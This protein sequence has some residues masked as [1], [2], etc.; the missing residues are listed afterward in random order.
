MADDGDLTVKHSRA[1]GT[2]ARTGDLI[3]S[4]IELIDSPRK[5]SNDI[6]DY[7]SNGYAGSS[8]SAS[9]TDCFGDFV[10]LKDF[11]DNGKDNPIPIEEFSEFANKVA[12][13]LMKHDLDWPG[14]IGGRD[15]YDTPFY[16]GGQSSKRTGEIDSENGKYPSSQQVCIEFLGCSGRSEINYMAQ[17]MWGA[18]VDE[19]I[20]IT[21][22][23]VTFW[24]VGEYGKLPSIKTYA[25][26]AYGYFYYKFYSTVTRPQ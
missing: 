15:V 16:N 6:P 26:T 25:W 9:L 17:G 24:K 4:Q 23:I 8:C 19:P 10:S 1:V 21:Y 11:K 3:V 7:P 20:Q 13:D 2:P 18:A 14:Y 12:E 5:L 22:G